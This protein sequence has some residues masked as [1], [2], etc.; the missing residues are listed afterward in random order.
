MQRILK[1]HYMNFLYSHHGLFQTPFWLYG[2]RG[3]EISRRESEPVG[4][5][6][7]GF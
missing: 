1:Q 4:L 2:N 7:I 5:D 6:S 3:T